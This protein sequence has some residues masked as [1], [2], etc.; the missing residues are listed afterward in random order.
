VRNLPDVTLAR[1]AEQAWV[2]WPAGNER[3]LEQIL[4]L[5]GVI[6][7]FRRDPHWHRFGCQLPTFDVPIAA[8]YQPLQ[9]VL[10]PYSFQAQKPPSLEWEPTELALVSDDRPR[11]TTAALY[12]LAQLTDWIEKVPTPRLNGIQ[13]ARCGDQALLFGDRLPL[14]PDGDRFWGSAVLMPLGY[15]PDPFLP[16][17]ALR[18][19]LAVS[20]DEVILWR[21]EG[22][23]T[24]DRRALAPLSR[25]GVRLAAQ[26]SA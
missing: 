3:V 13:A 2:R 10:T 4:P 21:Q 20:Q 11:P 15:R 16:A 18:E 12:S 24:I 7:Y 22:V 14:L 17:S 19:A 25:A 8:E 23:E 26:E 9:Q 5:P 1:I 6:L